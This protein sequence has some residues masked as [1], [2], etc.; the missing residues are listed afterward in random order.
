MKD[1]KKNVTL[2]FYV[3]PTEKKLL[4]FV[5]QRLNNIRPSSWIR[6]QI[7]RLAEE[8]YS[9]YKKNR[10]LNSEVTSEV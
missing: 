1:N 3:N 6:Q 4:F 10:Q 8:Q 2:T 7:V 9:D 5:A